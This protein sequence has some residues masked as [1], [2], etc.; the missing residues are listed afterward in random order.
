MGAR[1]GEEQ[2]LV[3]FADR[4]QGTGVYLPRYAYFEEGSDRAGRIC[5]QPL[6]SGKYRPTSCSQLTDLTA[7]L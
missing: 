7:R 4:A 5:Q 3:S 1:A 6:T 2:S